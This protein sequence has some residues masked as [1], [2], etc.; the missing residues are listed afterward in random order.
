MTVPTNGNNKT[1]TRYKTLSLLP[2]NSLLMI[3]TIAQIQRPPIMRSG[4]NIIHSGTRTL[5]SN[6]IGVCNLMGRYPGKYGERNGF[7]IN[8]DKKYSF[9]FRT[10]IFLGKWIKK[11]D[12]C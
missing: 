9:P 1:R 11:S 6:I 10:S 3:S 7:I 5:N 2:P 8:F 12:K 4:S